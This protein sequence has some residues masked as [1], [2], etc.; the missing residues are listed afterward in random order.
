MYQD[1]FEG[2]YKQDYLKRLRVLLISYLLI[3]RILM[4]AKLDVY[5]LSVKIKSST[6][7]ML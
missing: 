1:S 3:Q 7:K 5:I 6:I 2:L 4:Q